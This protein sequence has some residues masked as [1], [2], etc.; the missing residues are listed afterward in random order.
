MRSN[1]SSE[2]VRLTQAACA[3]VGESSSEVAAAE[4]AVRMAGRVA[5]GT[6]KSHGRTEDVLNRLE[7]AEAKHNRLQQGET[8]SQ[9]DGFDCR[10]CRNSYLLLPAFW[11][12]PKSRIQQPN[13]CPLGS[14]ATSSQRLSKLLEGKG[15]GK[16]KQATL[17][18]QQQPASAITPAMKQHARARISHA[19]QDNPA[20]EQGPQAGEEDQEAAAEAAASR[21]ECGIFQS[22]SSKSAY[23]SKLSN[24]ISQI[25]RAS[26]FAQ[27][28]VPS[29]A[30]EPSLAWQ[31]DRSAQDVSVTKAEARQGADKVLGRTEQQHDP[32]AHPAGRDQQS[33]ALQSVSEGEL[34]RLMGLLSGK[35][36]WQQSVCPVFK[37]AEHLHL[38]RR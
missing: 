28:G 15:K 4:E 14:E 25:K 5:A 9:L 11:T 10:D 12:C 3:G 33:S 19:L 37:F 13:S 22:S 1:D 17:P 31:H 32:E 2:A 26:E 8:C 21:W 23:L 16:P 20:L 38:S 34:K 18:S 30:S 29:T 24:A 36:Y 35:A 7:A 6:G 27:L